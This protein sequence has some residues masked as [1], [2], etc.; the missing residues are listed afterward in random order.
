MVEYRPLSTEDIPGVRRWWREHWSGE[1]M[2][3]HGEVFRPDPLSGFVA[4]EGN[5][6]VGLVTYRMH[7]GECEIMSL[8]SL[9]EQKGIGTRLMQNVI[10]ESRRV[11]CRRVRLTTTNDNLNALKFYQKRGFALVTIRRNALD[12]TRKIK[13][14]IPLIGMNGIPLRDEIELEF[15]L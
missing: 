15:L 7:Q 2:V 4:L 10:E 9:Q 13:P 1:T 3:V 11:G 8:D 6:W 5:R 12:E 14:G